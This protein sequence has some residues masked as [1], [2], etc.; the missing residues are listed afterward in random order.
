MADRDINLFNI[1]MSQTD[2]KTAYKF[3][4]NR[5]FTTV[6]IEQDRQFQ[7][8]RTYIDWQ[9][10]GKDDYKTDKTWTRSGRWNIGIRHDCAIMTLEEIKMYLK[11]SARILN[12]G[13]IGLSVI[14]GFIIV[15]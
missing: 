4:T 9:W 13:R 7:C 12:I 11:D 6:D 1:S 2:D 3:N 8:N 10:V 15:F 5:P 14:L